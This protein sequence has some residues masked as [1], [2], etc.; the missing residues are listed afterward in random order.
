M[1]KS[2]LFALCIAL[3]VVTALQAQQEK[4]ETGPPDG[5]KAN[6][7]SETS[8]PK[9]PS[10]DAL[11]MTVVTKT[12]KVNKFAATNGLKVYVIF[13]GD[14]MH[15][16]QLDN[17]RKNDLE[18]GATDT[19]KNLPVDVPLDE[20]KTLVLAVEGN[21]MWKCEFI[22][23][24]FF[25]KGMQ[26][27]EYKFSPDRFL[28]GSRERKKLNA[29]THLEFKLT[30]KPTLAPPDAAAKPGKSDEKSTTNEKPGTK[31]KK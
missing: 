6:S 26:S 18:L 23:F 29:T 30:T 16:V 15:K 14:P 7:T 21:D 24:Q 9:P 27:R 28:S 8:K 2:P 13:N 20:I 4:K 22:S 17:P 5:A 11:T 25:Q 3:I 12:G 19:F 1:R 10:K 31:E